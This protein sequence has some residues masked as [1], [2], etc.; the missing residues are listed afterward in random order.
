MLHLK[1]LKIYRNLWVSS[2]EGFLLVGTSSVYNIGNDRISLFLF[3]KCLYFVVYTGVFV[4]TRICKLGVI[5]Q[6]QSLQRVWCCVV[7]WKVRVV[8]RGPIQR[9]PVTKELSTFLYGCAPILYV[10]SR[11]IN[12]YFKG[13]FHMAYYFKQWEFIS[14]S[15]YYSYKRIMFSLGF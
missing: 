7:L 3:V 5:K 2:T 4:P 13:F 14:L 9:G 6:Y 10:E 12:T 15:I 11:V 8:S 1:L